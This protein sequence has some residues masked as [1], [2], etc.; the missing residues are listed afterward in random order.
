MNTAKTMEAAL[1]RHAGYWAAKPR[2]ST[3]GIDAEL[4]QSAGYWAAWTRAEDAVHWLRPAAPDGI[5]L[6]QYGL[7]ALLDVAQF[8]ALTIRTPAW[9][10]QEVARI[11]ER[12]PEPA[13]RLLE[14]MTKAAA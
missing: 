13:L 10:I 14:E 7:E 5:D 9:F 2:A 12:D 8:A 1:M 6:W 3:M 4:A 11:A